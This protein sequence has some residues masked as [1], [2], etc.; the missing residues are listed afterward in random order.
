[1]PLLHRWTLKEDTQAIGALIHLIPESATRMSQTLEEGLDMPAEKLERRKFEDILL[2]AVQLRL[3]E[4]RAKRGYR[5]CS[6]AVS[7]PRKFHPLCEP[8]ASPLRVQGAHGSHDT[9]RLKEAESR[10]HQSAIDI[11]HL[12]K[13]SPVWIELTSEMS[14]KFGSHCNCRMDTKRAL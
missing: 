1:M 5:P 9:N 7:A 13:I 2:S 10:I 12:Q 4:N 6:F 14:A 3:R 11:V 8:S